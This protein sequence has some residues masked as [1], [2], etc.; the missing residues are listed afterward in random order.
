MEPLLDNHPE[1]T[2]ILVET[3]RH[4]CSNSIWIGKMN[5]PEIRLDIITPFIKSYLDRQND[6]NILNIY[7]KMTN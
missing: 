1:D 2:I 3:L 5:K 4:Y 7:I 6:D